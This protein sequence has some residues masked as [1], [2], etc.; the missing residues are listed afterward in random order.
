MSRLLEDVVFSSPPPQCM[1]CGKRDPEF[2]L[3]IC[4]E[5]LDVWRKLKAWVEG[6]K[7][8]QYP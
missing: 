5:C 1:L 3:I 7:E 4:S 2:G 6:K 8:I